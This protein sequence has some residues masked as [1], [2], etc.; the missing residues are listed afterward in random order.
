[1]EVNSLLAVFVPGLRSGGLSVFWG[2][3]ALSLV[4]AGLFKRFRPLRLIGLAMFMWVAIKVFF[5]DLA[6]LDPIYKIVA[7]ILLGIVI[8]AGAYAYLRFQDRFALDS[9]TDS[10]NGDA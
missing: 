4:S 5:H 7:F 1:L 10:V 8:L 2:L 6:S 3:F 9:Q